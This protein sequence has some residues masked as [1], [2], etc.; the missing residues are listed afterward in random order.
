MDCGLFLWGSI[1]VA[2]A[3][4]QL[5]PKT[6][7]HSPVFSSDS[8]EVI[9]TIDTLGTYIEG[10]LLD[11]NSEGVF[12]ATIVIQGTTIGTRTDFDGKFILQIPDDFIHQFIVLNVTSLGY[13]KLSSKFFIKKNGNTNVSFQLYIDNTKLDSPIIIKRTHVLGLIDYN[14]K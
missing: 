9:T 14:P 2:N 10:I 11:K 13:N 1:K 7:V 6:N 5:L 3:E 4:K 8:I 12:P